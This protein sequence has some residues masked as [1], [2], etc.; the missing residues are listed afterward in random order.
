[1]DNREWD[2]F[3]EY[4]SDSRGDLFSILGKIQSHVT[5]IVLQIN[6]FKVCFCEIRDIPGIDQL[7]NMF[8]NCM[9]ELVLEGVPGYSGTREST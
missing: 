7:N 5:Q 8:H 4:L 3:C 9:W 1:M 6:K 2:F